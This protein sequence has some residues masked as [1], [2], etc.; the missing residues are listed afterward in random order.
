MVMLFTDGD[1]KAGWETKG[2]PTAGTLNLRHLWSDQEE[3]AGSSSMVGSEKRCWATE[4]WTE[5]PSAQRWHLHLWGWKTV[6]RESIT[7][8]RRLWVKAEWRWSYQERPCANLRSRQPSKKLWEGMILGRQEL[9]VATA[10]NGVKRYFLWLW[11]HGG[12]GYLSKNSF[13][14]V[15]KKEGR[16]AHSEEFMGASV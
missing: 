13:S 12:C 14:G 11:K 10:P 3:K 16:L 4:R 6:L 8:K 2:S 9:T 7:T 15:R 1:K 5:G